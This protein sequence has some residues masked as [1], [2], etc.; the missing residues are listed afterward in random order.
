MS[1]IQQMLLGAGGAVA[2]KTYVDDV[3]STYLY[4]GTGSSNHSILNGI[5]LA[6]EG[7]LVWTKNRD[8][9]F[10]S[11]SLFD[12]ERGVGQ[13]L[14]SNA[15]SS[16]S[17]ESNTLTAFLNNGFKLNGDN[18]A[19]ESGDNFSS[20]TFR[21]APGFLDIVEWSGNGA[22]R[23]INHNLGSVPGMVV[24]KCK[25]HSQ[26][27][28]IWHKSFGYT[29]SF[30][31]NRDAM[32][33]TGASSTWNSTDP[34]A[35]QISIGSSVVNA[36]GRDYVAYVFAG[37]K[38]TAATARS[39]VFDGSN[40]KVSIPDST[41]FE[42]GSGD[43]TVEAWVK[44]SNSAGTG[45]SAHTI[46]NK[47]DNTSN[48]KE[49][50]LRVNGDY[51]Q[52]LQTTDGNSNQITTG[53]TVIH[54]GQ[55]YH[56]AVVGHSGTIKLFVNGIQQASTA[57]QGTINSYSNPLIF[58]YNESSN[59]Q[60]MDGSI[61]NC[62]IVKGTAVYTSSFNPPTEPLTNITNTKLLCLNNSSVT[63]STVSPGTLT[64]DGATASS[65][66]PFDDPAA[67]TFGDSEEG[68]IKCG[69][70][71]GNGSESDGM[72]VF[73]GFEPAWLMVKRS[74][75]S[76]HWGIIDTMR[77][78]TAD[79]QGDVLFPN[80]QNVEDNGANSALPTSTGFKLHTTNN[81][82][83]G[84]ND[85]YMYVA[86]RRPD[87]YVGKPPS[88]GTD[89]FAMA[90]A[91]GST[92]SFIS[93]F[94]VDWALMR[95][96]DTANNWSSSGRLAPPDLQP[97]NANE[98]D[99]S[100]S[101]IFKFDHNNGWAVNRSSPRQS[102]MWKRHAGFDVVTYKGNGVDHHVNHS[103]N[104]VPEMMW[105]KKRNDS[106][107]WYVYHSGLDG[108]NSPEDYSLRL[109]T[110]ALEDEDGD[111]L[112]N[113]TVPTA[114]HFRINTDSGVNAD[115]DDYIAMLF[116]SVSGISKVGRYTGNGS[117]TGPII[118]TGFAPRFL[119]IRR[120]GPTEGDNWNVFDT[121]RGFS[122][123]NDPLLKLNNSNAQLTGYDLVDPTSDGFQLVTTDSAHNSSNVNYVY[124]AHA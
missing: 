89:A 8:D 43:F 26:N 90:V 45:A 69:S 76:A 113:Q 31:F 94:P 112:W 116:S 29:H 84:S 23:L 51:L 41:D 81:E 109:N 24:V 39:V 47:W 123:G 17:L 48:A 75:G 7:G 96:P 102:W 124:Y 59:G 38:S 27:W 37:G 73:L 15:S 97:D 44:Q 88:L 104:Q 56:V 25:S 117:N 63:G 100:M 119:I 107:N 36:S 34:T 32:P 67:F 18:I 33:D 71:K 21:K 50:I 60:W 35:T 65:D 3:F 101:S 2:T 68:I 92:P 4:K 11:H 93:N 42:F 55:W 77:G 5:D 22:N 83:N 54:V 110:T 99:T 61:S 70:Y 10:Y 58:G 49:W 20:W 87:G 115:G 46:V 9:A 62:R 28:Q 118:T 74:N 72:E 12:T 114:T 120:A 111:T 82:W 53:D 98:E 95:L 86:I 64:N 106:K 79:G 91:N 6:G 40:D 103:M 85:T 105:F 14:K 108:G 19:N 13:I 1:P 57:T 66:S 16:Q 78:W 121:V 80:R 52:W 30:A 122:S